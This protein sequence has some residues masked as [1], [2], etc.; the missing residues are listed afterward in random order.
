MFKKLFRLLALWPL[1]GMLIACSGA[2]ENSEALYIIDISHDPNTT[3]NSVSTDDI[4]PSQPENLHAVSVASNS[5]QLQWAASTDNVAV[6]GYR[7]FRDSILITSING[8]SYQDTTVTASTSYQYYVEAYDAANNS[9]VSNT[10]SVTTL[11][12]VIPD[13]TPPTV[14]ANLRTST[15]PTASSVSLVWNAATDN[16][17]VSGYRIYR[18]G[19]LRTITASTSYVD[20]TVLASTSYT[21]VAIAF[22]TAN[23]TSSSNT[24]AINTPAPADISAPTAPGNLRTFSTPTVAQVGL[25]WNAS[26]DNVGVAYYRVYRNSTQISQTTNTTYTDNSVAAGTSYSYTIRAYD[27]AG[28]YSVSSTLQ[29]TTPSAAAS[30]SLSWIPPT[31][32]SDDSALTDLTGYVIYYGVSPAALNSSLSVSFGLTE[33]IIEN[34]Q[35]GVTYYFAIT[36]VN[37]LGVESDLSNIV[38]KTTG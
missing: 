38:N 20:N 29:V 31:Q 5:V 12:L 23:N 37:S 33:V 2:S 1:A 4:S 34:L 18:N 21:Y 26:T 8:T 14:P 30:T 9:N 25:I 36:A 16:I 22:D 7:I 19:V 6:S 15:S 3:E 11:V 32:N 24:L 27:A 13:T 17:G 28:N 10:L 35:S